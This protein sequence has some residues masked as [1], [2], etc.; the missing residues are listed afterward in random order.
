MF[1]INLGMCLEKVLLT[2]DVWYWKARQQY[3]SH[4]WKRI[5]FRNSQVQLA[6][7]ET[8][9]FLLSSLLSPLSLSLPLSS[10]PSSLS[11]FLFPLSLPFHPYFFPFT[12]QVGETLQDVFVISWVQMKTNLYKGMRWSRLRTQMC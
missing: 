8:T 4:L 2:P 6:A 7:L 3:Y 9:R 11:S 5:Q 1:P 12:L 10:L